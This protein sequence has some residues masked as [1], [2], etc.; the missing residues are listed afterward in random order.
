MGRL[1]STKVA[2]QNKGTKT[3]RSLGGYGSKRDTPARSAKQVTRREL[4]LQ[5]ERVKTALDEAR[6]H[7]AALDQMVDERAG[8]GPA[9]GAQ[10]GAMSKQALGHI[11]IKTCPTSAWRENQLMTGQSCPLCGMAFGDCDEK[12][13]TS[14]RP[15]CRRCADVGE[16]VIHAVKPAEKKHPFEPYE[17]DGKAPDSIRTARTLIGQGYHV[18]GV[19]RRTGVGFK[20]VEDL[21]GKDGYA[22]ENKA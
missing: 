7:E 1:K 13:R 14:G 6:K 5:E 12:Q 17:G 11:E 4:R 10:Y 2:R 22:K 16:L 3:K 20:W 18:A 15:C 19:M 8:D 9:V 21:V